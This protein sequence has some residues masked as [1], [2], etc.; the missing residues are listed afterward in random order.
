MAHCRDKDTGGNSSG[1]YSFGVSPLGGCHFL[2]KTWPHPTACGLQ[3]WDASG[4]TTN[5]M[6]IQPEPSADRPLKVF[7][8]KQP[9]DKHTA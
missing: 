3:C 1:E 7:L 6:G 9:P 8:K 4:Q 2:N 5:R